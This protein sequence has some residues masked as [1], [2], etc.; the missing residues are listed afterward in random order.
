[1]RYLWIDA[2]CILQDNDEDKAKECAKMDQIYQQ[3]YVMISAANADDCYY[4]FLGRVSSFYEDLP[5]LPIMCPNG[6][7]GSVFLVLE[8]KNLFQ[9]P[10]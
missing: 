2:L 10:L 5:M 6:Q 9:D 7:K 8:P 4:G 1:M 3:A